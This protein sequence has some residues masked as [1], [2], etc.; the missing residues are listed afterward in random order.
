VRKKQKIETLGKNK[1]LREQQPYFCSSND[2]RRSDFHNE[3]QDH[4]LS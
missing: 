4:V 2:G 1:K 3:L